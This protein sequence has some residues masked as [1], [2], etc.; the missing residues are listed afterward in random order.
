MTIKAII[1]N[2]NEKEMSILSEKQKVLS[3]M[4]YKNK[5]Y[6]QCFNTLF[7]MLKCFESY[8]NKIW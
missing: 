7:I 3:N 5:T 2:K 4:I 8:Q 1:Y 6:D